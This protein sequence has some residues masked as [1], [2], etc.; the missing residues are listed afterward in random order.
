MF[1]RAAGFQVS[2]AADRELSRLQ[3]LGGKPRGEKAP[4][5]TLDGFGGHV[6]VSS[7]GH[8]GA[9]RELAKAFRV[10]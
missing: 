3:L 5:F 9:I 8:R 2:A 7:E 10:S 4:S 1:A 6:E